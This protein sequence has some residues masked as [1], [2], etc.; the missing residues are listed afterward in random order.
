MSR[1]ENRHILME[2]RKEQKEERLKAQAELREK[3]AIEGFS[4]KRPD[5][6]DNAKCEYKTEAEQLEARR[7]TTKDYLKVLQKNLPSLL[8]RLSEVTDYRKPKKIKHKVAVNLLFCIIRSEL[9]GKSDLKWTLNPVGT[10]H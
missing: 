3:Q 7:Q 5:T 9:D 8:I 1:I 2:E 6:P 4:N 10:G